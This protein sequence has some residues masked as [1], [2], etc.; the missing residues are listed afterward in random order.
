V[1]TELNPTRFDLIAEAHGCLGIR[2]KTAA[3]LGPALDKAFA[4]EVPVVVDAIIDRDATLALR[5]GPKLR[6][7]CGHGAGTGF[8]GD[9][10]HGYLT[11][12]AA[13]R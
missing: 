4:T 6:F 1:N 13:G 5:A 10:G 8:Q 9:L 7:P 2:M 3:D 11:L 12:Q